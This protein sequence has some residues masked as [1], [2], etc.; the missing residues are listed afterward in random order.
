MGSSV[1]S[2]AVAGAA[3][4][5]WSRSME[6]RGSEVEFMLREPVHSTEDIRYVLAS[7]EAGLMFMDH[8]DLKASQLGVRPGALSRWILPFGD[9]GQSV[10]AQASATS[11]VL[12]A[13]PPELRRKLGDKELHYLVKSAN[14]VRKLIRV[15]IADDNDLQ[16]ARDALAT[17]AR[18]FRRVT[19]EAQAQGMEPAE[20]L[21]RR[22]EGA[23]G[24]GAL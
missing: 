19:D 9:D 16:T 12:E 8:L 1:G 21:V 18:F 6:V 20:L 17:A 11:E 22:R 2:A 10:A 14:S 24:I 13:M 15:K 23:K 7:A 4:K 5:P 3:E